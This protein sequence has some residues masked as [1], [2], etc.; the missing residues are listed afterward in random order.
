MSTMM[1]E[2]TVDLDSAETSRLL[3]ARASRHSA[4]TLHDGTQQTSRRRTTKDVSAMPI[5]DKDD[6]RAYDPTTGLIRDGVGIRVKMNLMDAA[7]NGMR[8][9][10]TQDDPYVIETG[11]APRKRRHRARTS[12]PVGRE[13]GEIL[14]ESDAAHRPGFRFG[15]A[16]RTASEDA[17]RQRMIEDSNAWRT[18]EM[19]GQHEY[20]FSDA[21]AGVTGA[22]WA[23]HQRMIADQEAWRRPSPAQW[24]AVPSGKYPM[25]AGIGSPCD[26]NGERGVLVEDGTGFLVCRVPRHLGPSRSGTTSGDAGTRGHQGITGDRAAVEAAWLQMVEDTA[27]AW[28]NK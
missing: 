7:P 16:G 25:S 28:R 27:N 14:E 19:I 8:G 13:S 17:R 9:R 4:V 2:S 21:P 5:Y 6:E 11:L 24:D 18:P 10:G 26:L 15:D 22:E 12:D 20:S 3:D 1:V 23:R